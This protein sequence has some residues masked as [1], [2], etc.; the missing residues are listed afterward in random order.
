MTMPCDAFCDGPTSRLMDQTVGRYNDRSAFSNNNAMDS[1]VH[2]HMQ[3]LAH[4]NMTLD[5]HG[6]ANMILQMRAVQGQ[7][8]TP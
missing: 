7:P 1:S 4:A 3:F 5:Q 2:M 8:G 6:L